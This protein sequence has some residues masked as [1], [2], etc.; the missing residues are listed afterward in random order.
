MRHHEASKPKTGFYLIYLAQPFPQTHGFTN[1]VDTAF[2]SLT[3]WLQLLV[4][5]IAYNACL[6]NFKSFLWISSDTQLSH[7]STGYYFRKISSC[8]G[9]WL[10]RR[11]WRQSRLH[12]QRQ[13]RMGGLVNDTLLLGAWNLRL[14]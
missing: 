10:F 13:L 7:P 14:S 9:L 6:W 1:R 8:G 5:Q 2:R 3:A 11:W 4:H 12:R